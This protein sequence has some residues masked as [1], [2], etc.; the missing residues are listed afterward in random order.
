MPIM[1]S[2]TTAQ[3]SLQINPPKIEPENSHSVIVDNSKVS[4][5]SLLTHVSGVSFVVDYYRLVINKDN[6]LYSQDVG[7][8]G[9]QQQYT[10]YKNFELRQQDSLSQDQDDMDKVFTV[11][12]IALVHSGLIPNEGD[13]FAGD[14]GDGRLGIFNVTRSQRMAIMTDTVYQI[15]YSLVYFS[16]DKPESFL[17]LE[18][19]VIDT[20]FYV[21]DRLDYNDSPYL[22]TE[23]YDFTRRL[24]GYYKEMSLNYFSWFFSKEFSAYIVPGQ[25]K[26]TFDYFLY[27]ALRVLFRDDKFNVLQKHQAINI[28]DDDLI[29]RG[30][31]LFSVLLERSSDKFLFCDH[32]AGLVRTDTFAYEG[33]TTNIRYTGIQSLVYPVSNE[34]R[35]DDGFNRVVHSVLELTLL[36]TPNTLDPATKAKELTSFTF[37]DKTV[38]LI[39][40]VTIDNNYIFSNDF[41]TRSEALSLIES[42][43]LLYIDGKTINPQ[44]LKVLCDN[45]KFWPRL[46]RFYYIPILIILIQSILKDV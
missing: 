24:G 20:Y 44:A 31:D 7:Q 41:Y 21:K 2:K 40:P 3:G 26:P 34:A 29:D 12:G 15:E 17:D 30:F 25:L 32:V 18:T 19:K 11:K 5:D 39:K 22:T 16:N 33:A 27:K 38:P 9:V 8:T 10:K 13:M 42:L 6:A 43:V 36:P 28:D 37:G 35:V 23:E 4:R 14:V 45:Y 46:E 1:K